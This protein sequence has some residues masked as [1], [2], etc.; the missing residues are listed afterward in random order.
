ML[1]RL[2]L[3]HLLLRLL[4]LTCHEALLSHVH[5]VAPRGAFQAWRDARRCRQTGKAGRGAGQ[6]GGDVRRAG[7]ADSQAAAKQPPLH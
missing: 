1:L 3:L 6:V 2:L 7:R 4:L 5:C